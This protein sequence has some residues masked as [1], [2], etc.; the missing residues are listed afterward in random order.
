MTGMFLSGARQLRVARPRW[1]ALGACVAGVVCAGSAHAAL[2]TVETDVDT[3]A[4]DGV[5]SLREALANANDPDSVDHSAGD[6]ATGSAGA[7]TITFDFDPLVTVPAIIHVTSPLPIASA[8]TID[9]VDQV[10]VTL[11][12]GDATRIFTIDAG[13][14]NPTVTLAN[15]TM[16]RGFAERGG[17]VSSTETLVVDHCYLHDSAA[18]GANGGVAGAAS[19]M[20]GALY[21]TAPLTVSDSV[22]AN[23]SSYGGHVDVPATQAGGGA[24]GGIGGAICVA[25]VGVA[26]SITRSYFDGNLAQGGGVPASTA[27]LWG[28]AGAGFGGAVAVVSGATLTVS[29]SVFV[30]NNAT[31]GQDGQSTAIFTASAAGT[32]NAGIDFH[33][34]DSAL[35]AKGGMGDFGSGG[36]GGSPGGDGGF[37]GGGGGASDNVDA[38][39]GTGGFGGGS[40]AGHSQVYSGGGAGFGGAIFTAA[41]TVTISDSTLAF[42]AASVQATVST[43]AAR[44]AAVFA[45]T[46]GVT[47][48]RSI[49]KANTATT[50]D[51]NSAQA[52]C[53][54]FGIATVASGGHNIIDTSAGCPSVASDL[55]ANPGLTA[56]GGPG[57]LTGV[58][59]PTDCSSNVVDAAGAGCPATDLFGATRPSG[60][61]CDIGAV[62]LVSADVSYSI[63]QTGV[64]LPGQDIT[65]PLTVASAA[66]ASNVVAEL[67]LNQL[68]FVSGAGCVVQADPTKVRCSAASV[69]PGASYTPSVVL[70]LSATPTTPSVSVAR[71]SGD[72]LDCNGANNTQTLNVSW[73]GN[74]VAD[75]ARGETCD[76]AG[77]AGG[78]NA[79][80]NGCDDGYKGPTCASECPGGHA[81]QCNL[82]GECVEAGGVAVCNC[83]Q[84]RYG[85]ACQ[86]FCPGVVGPAGTDATECG[87]APGDV[88]GTCNDGAAGNGQCVCAAGWYITG[89]ADAGLSSGAGVCTTTKCGDGVAKG[90]EGCD[91]NNDLT[92][93]NCP[94][95]PSGTC[96]PASCGDGFI[97]QQ[98]PTIEECDGGFGSGNLDGCVEGTPGSPICHIAIC[99][100]G[101]RRT[102]KTVGQV[103]YEECDD[104]NPSNTDTCTTQCKSAVCGDGFTQPGEAC[105]DGNHNNNDGCP[106]DVANGGNCQFATCGDGFVNFAGNGG[107]AGFES[108]DH[109][110]TP[111]QGCASCQIAPGYLCDGAKATTCTETCDSDYA[112][113][114][115]KDFMWQQR[116]DNTAPFTFGTT[117][118]GGAGWEVALGAAKLPAAPVTSGIWHAIAVPLA[119]DVRDPRLLITYSL[120]AGATDCMR[121]Y[122]T[123][124]PVLGAATPAGEKCGPGTGTLDVGLASLAGQ[125]SYV[126]IRLEAPESG[127]N[128]DGLAI[129]RV[130]VRGDFDG[131]NVT[132]Y[133]GKT[134]GDACVDKDQDGFGDPTSRDLVA[135][136]DVDP[137]ADCDDTVSAVKP[138]ALENCGDH[139]DNDCDSKTDAQ[140]TP[141]CGEDCA[142]GID[143]GGDG[144]S[145]CG[146][147]V[148]TGQAVGVSG[149]DAFCAVPCRRSFSYDTGPGTTTVEDMTPG[150]AVNNIWAYTSAVGGFTT[151]NLVKD[152]ATVTRQ[153]GRLQLKV[154]MTKAYA[155]PKP[156]LSITYDHDG[157]ATGRDVL[158]L[159]FSTSG[160]PTCQ[161]NDLGITLLQDTPTDDAVN[162]GFVTKTVDLS[163]YVDAS[164]L[165]I[166]VLF[167]TFEANPYP[168]AASGV[169]LTSLTIASD[170]DADGFFEGRSTGDGTT[171]DPCWDVDGDFYGDPLSPNLL[172]CISHG[173]GLPPKS[174]CDDTRINVNPDVA[175]EKGVLC[176]DGLNNDCD[177]DAQGN[178]LIDAFDSGCGTEDCANGVDDN[179]D[180]LVDC[181]G[182]V[183]AASSLSCQLCTFGYDFNTGKARDGAVAT[184]TGS[185]NGW[186]PSTTVATRLWDY[187]GNIVTIGTR[188]AIGW[189]T[190]SGGNVSDAGSGRIRG[191]LTRRVT[192]PPQMPKPEL[193]LTYHLVGDNVKD[194]FGVCFNVA[195]SGCGFQNGGTGTLA[196]SVVWSTHANTTQLTTV[197]VPLPPNQV[198]VVLFYDTDDGNNNTN[199]G[200]F[201]DQVEISSDADLDGIGEYFGRACDDCVDADHDGYGDDTFAVT[202]L[203]ACP[204]P[205]VRDCD[206]HDSRRNPGLAEQCYAAAD[207][208]DAIIPP[209]SGVN[210]NG[211]IN[212]DNNCDGKIDNETP[213][214]IQCGNGFIETGETCDVLGNTNTPGCKDCQIKAGSVYVSEIHLPIINNNPAEQWIELHN[215]LPNDIDLR[216]LE[217]KMK[218]DRGNGTPPTVI[219]LL[220][221][222]DCQ[223]Q[224]GYTIDANL[225]G[226]R[227]YYVIAFGPVGS[228]DFAD[229]SAIDMICPGFAVAESGAGTILLYQG[230]DTS[231]VIDQVK[232]STLV[233]AS[234]STHFDVSPNV[235]RGRSLMLKAPDSNSTENDNVASW[236]LA[237]PHDTYSV[238]GSHYGSPGQAGV[239]G[240][241][242]CDGVDDDCDGGTDETA[243]YTDA[244]GGRELPDADADG[245]CDAR[246]CDPALAACAFPK[247]DAAC[248]AD[249]DGDGIINCKDSCLDV[250]GDGFGP[251]GAGSPPAG[252]PVAGAC[253][254]EPSVCDQPGLKTVFPRAQENAAGINGACTN[255]LDDD[256]DLLGDCL[257]SDCFGQD[258]CKAETCQTAKALACG[259]G[260]TATPNTVD[261][262]TCFADNTLPETGKDKAYSFKATD[263]GKVRFKLRNIGTRLFSMRVTDNACSD[264]S[265]AAGQ[266]SAP[267][268][269]A[270]GGT[271][272]AEV[273]SDCLS[274]ATLDVD[275]VAGRTYYIVLKTVGDCANGSSPSAELV[276]SCS[277]VGHCAP[278]GTPPVAIDEDAD[279]FTDCG[280]SDC[281]FD[282]ACID[283]DFDGDGV[284]NKLEQLCGTNPLLPTENLSQD[285]FRQYDNDNLINCVDPDD[286]NDGTPDAG[287]IDVDGP[288]PDVAE[289]ALN[290]ATAKNDPTI[291]PGAPKQ[292]NKVLVDADC[293]G[294]FD[295]TE[296]ECGV[297]EDVCADGLDNDNDGKSDC[298]DPDCVPNSLCRC[299]DFDGDGFSNEVE[300]ECNTDPLDCYPN[301]H[302]DSKPTPPEIADDIEV[303]G[304]AVATC[305]N[306]GIG[307]GIPN[308]ADPDDDGDGFPDTEEI[309]CG[310][311]PV[312]KA[313]VPL[314]TDG[315]SQCDAVDPNDDNDSFGGFEFPDVLEIQCQSD[316]KDPLS[317]PWD[318]AHDADH[319]H[320]CNAL[321]LDDDGDGWLD[322]EEADCETD[323]LSSASNP[324]V[325]G[326]DL[327]G[328]HLC[329]KVDLND[330]GDAWLDAD[331][332]AC[333]T[334]PKDALS[335]PPDA[336]EDGKCDAVDGDDDGDGVPDTTE[337]L[338]GTDPLD[339]TD[340]P[341]AEEA[342]DLDNDGIANCVDPDDD[343]DLV[344][345]ANELIYGSNPRN[346]DSDGDGLDD[347]VENKDHD[348]EY[349][350][351]ETSA[352]KKD[353]DND[354]LNDKVEVESCYSAGAGFPCKASNPRLSDSDND[355]VQDSFEDANKNGQTDAG[356]TSPVMADS[357]GD[358]VVDGI[359]KECATNPL[360]PLSMPTD[361]DEDGVCDGKQKDTD[362]DGIADGVETFCGTDPLD[363][364]SVPSLSDLD[365]LDDDGKINCV[366]PDDDDDQV[367][368]DDEIECN[369]DSRDP[370]KTPTADDIGD[371]DQDGHLN[372]SDPDDDNDT[373]SD[374]AEAQAQTNPK[375]ADTDDDGL[376]DG[377]ELLVIGTNPKDADTDDDGIDDGTEFGLTTPNK[378]TAG[379]FQ[380]DVDPATTTDPKNPDTD[381]DGVKDGD[382]DTNHNGKVDKDA[383][384]PEGNPNDPTDGL[385]DT[386]G[387]GLI[388][389]EE[390]LIYHTDPNNP[391]TDGDQRNDKLE[392]TVDHTDP[393]NPDTDGGG[394]IDGF[395]IRNGTDPNEKTDDFSTT[396]IEGGSVFSCSGG[397]SVATLITTFLTGLG[398]L[399]IYRRRK[400]A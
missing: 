378:D 328:D 262:A 372:C 231:K 204:N 208:P 288:G 20:G 289:C 261:F 33:G 139:I 177:F 349:D 146:D 293:N 264:H 280:D 122:L 211:G 148:C 350:A 151:P 143:D 283:G 196:S 188:Q 291:H 109:G 282:A 271:N 355:G 157:A 62:E 101:I 35:N 201:L 86:S 324:T 330:D 37:G 310:S 354:G 312:S 390:I 245:V 307:D 393:L 292:C 287:E 315:D 15:L 337:V 269:L 45:Q 145:D 322:F 54:L 102:D 129:T 65:F 141:R 61:T 100:D 329:D 191:W 375:D 202:D 300:I 373:L 173:S 7:D 31:G 42:N 295:T 381:G 382:E 251:N 63:S 398:L 344:S 131:D 357:D 342:L 281:V 297:H 318:D 156:V 235:S 68:T 362:G 79:T 356:E 341:L 41:A 107:G 120:Q 246:D 212:R 339:K 325:E 171:C 2:I 352:I 239:C 326:D 132:D 130:R 50:A 203:T 207:A 284:S 142:N 258:V 52:G 359:E 370:T 255:G 379:A 127:A 103:G 305:D 316:P 270:S 277:E 4:A 224:T 91:D 23:N 199:A 126:T 93:D 367:V 99:G 38:S 94:S 147:P 394:V 276:V 336:D 388:D 136:T 114:A 163:Q 227:P 40:G 256:C 110:G 321:D 220:D 299:A 195:A 16:T 160:P 290:F 29:G 80:C 360:D 12:G 144:T 392:L 98:I 273:V 327:D 81:N 88:H 311:N 168:A 238:T 113:A 166:A 209:G 138:S 343:G 164:D 358:T 87:N 219:D 206:D 89:G 18:I 158:A 308:C 376:S 247:T 5:C 83:A 34:G 180:T 332:I 222:G 172:A 233:C 95:G 190:R 135:C 234:G 9:G 92:N 243:F 149:A 64:G 108:C 331:E 317:T 76:D 364:H 13:A 252:G 334:D 181:A 309:V 73:C 84:G 175:D 259:D 205:D 301:P 112:F 237:G 395:E 71:F 97:D 183:C 116:S 187:T 242:A 128:R 304:S 36:G 184:S 21:T 272:P 90:T 286:D 186:T 17:L 119:G 185:S 320:L 368:D 313:S 105:D 346:K 338:C 275:T 51:G 150:G 118:T 241:L 11:H 294:Q 267:A 363:N 257:D 85:N 167:D 248:T 399:V 159:C 366:D 278:T 250:D 385:Q 353:S 117:H 400:K 189:G 389:R 133:K 134:C 39:G 19:G 371:Y 179:D 22:F 43:P 197:R 182:P 121:V 319:D 369:V 44:G 348:G 78:C 386:D 351:S 228:T 260:A 59:R 106:D 69:G 194:T 302:C 268:A 249:A 47:I 214:C 253:Y 200:V 10:D 124:T 365:D 218:Y 153:F 8:V 279:G 55:L 174:D 345:D 306:D 333:G 140:D 66:P 298:D 361:K 285:P 170:A 70:H 192:V 265:T 26:V 32:G 216:T 77:A 123:A 57:P 340:K 58:Y 254:F 82:Q 125:V 223:V 162:G 155:G 384:P 323:P 383:T 1:V 380:P 137:S 178:P 6:C 314:N 49:L 176:A 221:E 53:G 115:A 96:Q 46:G 74:G 30:S 60:A 193:V 229:T 198:D 377:Q 236:C 154:K 232:P 397:G 104:G 335:F 240:E 75:G 72:T 226:K 225:P 296:A 263:T 347:G 274:G 266:C 27:S 213:A 165:Y 14:D 391:D 25:S 387:D 152:S 396:T 169:T 48:T 67:T 303:P 56:F 230:T 161:G 215:G 217:V 244:L 24:G 210:P 3:V 28:G 111:I 374:V